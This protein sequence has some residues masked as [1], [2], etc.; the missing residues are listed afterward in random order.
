MPTLQEMKTLIY[1]KSAQPTQPNHQGFTLVEL[2]LVLTI[3][4]IL[5]GIV[6][7]RVTGYGDRARTAATQAEIATISAALNAYEVDNGSYPK[8]NGGL[9]SLITKPRDAANWK[10]PYLHANK[11][12]LDK[13]KHPYIY[14][15]PGKHN[16]ADFDLYSLGKDGLGG[17]NTIGN[18]LD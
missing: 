15:T 2:L 1:K 3:L 18:W 8:A 4:A 9:Q 6:I 17:T 16:P 7:P 14:L 5:A 11:V 12:P 13:W 10:G